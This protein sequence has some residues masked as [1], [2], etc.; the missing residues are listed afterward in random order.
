MRFRELSRSLKM[1]CLSTFLVSLCLLSTA[2]SLTAAGV[3]L[4]KKAPNDSEEYWSPIEFFS[5]EN[6]PTSVVI[7]LKGTKQTSTIPRHQIGEVIEF[8]DFNVT[9]IVS[10]DAVGKIK[11]ARDSVARHASKCKQ[12][13]GILSAM[14][15]N[16]DQ[17]LSHYADGNV[18][19]AG[20]WINKHEYGAKLKADA[21]AST[22]GSI[23]EVV[24]GAKS[25]KNVR[26]TKVVGDRISIM[27]EG[28]IASLNS[29]DLSEETRMRMEIAFPKYFQKTPKTSGTKNAPVS[30]GT[31]KPAIV[32]TTPQT[33]IGSGTL[34]PSTLG[35]STRQPLPPLQDQSKRIHTPPNS[36][37]LEREKKRILAAAE[38]IRKRMTAIHP[39][40]SRD[41]GF[42]FDFSSG[43]MSFLD[44]KFIDSGY[45]FMLG[46]LDP[47]RIYEGKEYDKQGYST[48]F[49]QAFAHDDEPVIFYKHG[50]EVWNH[51]LMKLEPHDPVDTRKIAEALTFLATVYQGAPA[52]NTDDPA[53]QMEKLLSKQGFN[54]SVKI[55]DGLLIFRAASKFP[56]INH[57][58]TTTQVLIAD[59]DPEKFSRSENANP[60]SLCYVT[61][62]CV[63]GKQSTVVVEFKEKVDQGKSPTISFEA[64][65]RSDA[66]KILDCATKICVQAGWKKSEF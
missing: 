38:S 46:D 45:T 20:K 43:K 7:T 37:I 16:Y 5:I 39:D 11:A 62:K 17:V 21:L 10:E 29:G 48:P 49:I 2:P 19:I 56:E 50:A 66:D 65:N 55:K 27:H 15:Q 6:F 8:V 23:P 63:G 41:I 44:Q 59:L 47:E 35:P 52:L 28:G 42:V 61:M 32:E 54:I 31:D 34:P 4:T 22:A 60:E 3:V 36:A 57:A 9:S 30:E 64:V 14:V 58:V 51:R 33:P 12:A 53:T 1:K 26:V 18:L 13:A 24:A 40:S 25:F